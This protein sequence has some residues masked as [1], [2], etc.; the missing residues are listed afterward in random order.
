[1]PCP[2]AIGLCCLGRHYPRRGL[3]ASILTLLPGARLIT[4][5][6]RHHKEDVVVGSVIG[7]FSGTICYLLY[8]PNPFSA[9]SFSA[10]TMG[11][12]RLAAINGVPSESGGVEGYRLA[13]EGPDLESV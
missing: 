12:P 11:R 8:W 7:I 4:L 3:R 9:S 10:E 6:K 2:L 1:M 13:P 5:R